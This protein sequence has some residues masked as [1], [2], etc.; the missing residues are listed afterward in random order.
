ME[1]EHNSAHPP[2]PQQTP[3]QALGGVRAQA[4][5]KRARLEQEE[6]ERPF[7]AP[8]LSTLLGAHCK[9][10]RL[11]ISKARDLSQTS[12]RFCAQLLVGL[13]DN[14]HLTHLDISFTILKPTGAQV[15]AKVLA[16]NSALR[17]LRMSSCKLKAEGVTVVAHALRQNTSLTV[18]IHTHTHTHTHTHAHTRTHTHTHTHTNTHTQ[19]HTPFLR[20]CTSTAITPR[21]RG[22]RRWQPCYGYVLMTLI[23]LLILVPSQSHTALLRDITHSLPS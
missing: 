16:E 20:S 19:T 3:A 23:I 11:D 17:T 15:L 21:S 22:E 13:R 6:Q 12:Y 7:A 5:R 4:P 9:L 8:E 18:H 2:P 14:T 1:I 10:T